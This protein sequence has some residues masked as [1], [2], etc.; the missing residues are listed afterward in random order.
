MLTGCGHS[1]EAGGARAGI[2][3][4]E[5]IVAAFEGRGL[6]VTQADVRPQSIFQRELNGQEPLVFLLNG[7]EISLYPFP[8]AE[9]REAGM[10]DFEQHT[11]TADPVP[12]KVYQEGSLLLY[13]VQDFG[14]A[15][16]QELDAKIKGAVADLLLLADPEA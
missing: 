14:Q 15:V 1:D 6:E 7:D 13:Y 4:A 3:T 5:E 2:L 10:E 8:S 11:R 9:E 12:Y 16:E